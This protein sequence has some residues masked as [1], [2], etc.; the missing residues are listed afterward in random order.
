MMLTNIGMLG[1][2]FL[3]SQVPQPAAFRISAKQRIPGK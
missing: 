3:F 1:V 2:I